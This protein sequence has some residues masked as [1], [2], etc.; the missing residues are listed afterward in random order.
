MG[1]VP[2]NYEACNYQPASFRQ[3]ISNCESLCLVRHLVAKCGISSCPYPLSWLMLYET[4]WYSCN[5]TPQFNGSVSGTLWH[6]YLIWRRSVPSMTPHSLV[7]H[8]AMRFSNFFLNFLLS[9]NSVTSGNRSPWKSSF[10]SII[11]C[12]TDWYLLCTFSFAGCFAANVKQPIGQYFTHHKTKD[13]IIFNVV[14]YQLITTIKCIEKHGK[15][16]LY[17]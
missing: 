14:H 12:G 5:T 15:S 16:I 6:L 11:V 9:L 13:K 10:Q 2:T 8:S 4:T 3:R 1:P 17:L 7:C